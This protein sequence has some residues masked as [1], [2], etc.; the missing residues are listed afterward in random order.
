MGI[1]FVILKLTGEIE[2]SWWLV[3][4]PF[5]GVV[6][7]AVGLGLSALLMLLGVLLVV[8]MIDKKADGHLAKPTD[9]N[10]P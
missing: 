9:K 8:D 2:W 6:V 4:L 7:L 3:T 5:W 10:T 1:Y